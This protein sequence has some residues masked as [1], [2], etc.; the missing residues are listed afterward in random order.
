[1][2]NY[3][4][5]KQLLVAIFLILCVVCDA[6]LDVVFHKKSSL[7]HLVSNISNCWC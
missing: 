4:L 7:C 2:C 5:S 6:M 3:V 1:M